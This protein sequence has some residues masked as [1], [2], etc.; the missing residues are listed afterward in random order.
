VKGV[1]NEMKRKYLISICFIIVLLLFSINFTYASYSVTLTNKIEG[2]YNDRSQTTS[3]F[4]P[5]GSDDIT[6]SGD[7]KNKTTIDFYACNCGLYFTNSTARRSHDPENDHGYTKWYNA[8]YTFTLENGK[9]ATITVPDNAY[10]EICRIYDSNLT[11]DN[12][13]VQYSINNSNTKKSMSNCDIRSNDGI[14]SVKISKASTITVY[15]TDSVAV[16]GGVNTSALV[17]GFLTLFFVTL[18]TTIK[19]IKRVKVTIA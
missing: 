14:S 7:I 12:Q 3:Y 4:I 18:F 17:I 8:A 9:S 1:K 5:L 19:F 6:I 10:V 15:N 2:E 11:T 13:I 16:P